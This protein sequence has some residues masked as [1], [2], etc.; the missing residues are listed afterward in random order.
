M[1]GGKV[2]GGN[3]KRKCQSGNMEMS[4]S[5]LIEFQILRIKE[6]YKQNSQNPS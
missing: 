3:Y 6:S 2:E 4:G 1:G 5:A